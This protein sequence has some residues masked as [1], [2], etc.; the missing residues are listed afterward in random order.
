M[1]ISLKN[2]LIIFTVILLFFIFIASFMILKTLDNI[3][4]KFSNYKLVALNGKIKTLEISK[5]M[6]YISRCSRDIMLGNDF[7]M[8]FSKIQKRKKEIEDNFL[9]L[10]NSIRHMKDRGYNLELFKETQKSTLAFID[11]VILKVELIKSGKN[12][13]DVYQLYKKESTPLAVKSRKYFSQLAKNQDHSFTYLTQKFENEIIEQRGI[14]GGSALVF[15]LM[16]IVFMRSGFKNILRNIEVENS[17]A[18]TRKLLV[19]YKNA[20]DKTNIVSKTDL[21]GNITYVNDEFC[22]VSQ[23]NEDE[24]INKPHNIVRHP[25]MP[26]LAFEELWN[27][28]KEK[29]SW[30]GIVENKKKNGENYFV[31]TTIF[32]ILDNDGN[33]QEYIAIRK[34]ISELIE[35]NNKLV[36]SQEEIL[37]RIGM[38]AE[39]RSKETGNHVRR[40]AEY[41]KI[42]GKNYGMSEEEVS[43]L[44]NATALH[45]IGKVATPDRILNKTGKLTFEEF[46]EMKK[47]SVNGYNML[48]DSDNEIIKAGAI[49][50]HEHH[51]KYDGSGYPRGIA[52]D[53]IHIFARI[54]AIADV[55]DALGSK[56]SYKDAWSLNEI[57][58]FINSQ[59]G[60]HFD[61]ELVKIFNDRFDDFIF[62]R[63]KFNSD[64]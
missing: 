47:H 32:P 44:Y 27:T 21:R 8:N 43:L 2:K 41:S 9:V 53:E 29:K 54:T 33:V 61:P 62:I 42:L 5:D 40:V 4:T 28:I 20:I 22:K 31:D 14:V 3:E 37:T 18:N 45:D 56:R 1:Q 58:E 16:I 55:F 6:N 23:Y 64:Y 63:K 15:A 51:E 17:L 30:H 59:S 12:R 52:K 49:I 19:Q 57:V 38:I 25:N 10:E 7:E 13:S 24:L 36:S 39:T 34:D 50:A 26:K 48:K 35:L 46:E 60:K 11:D